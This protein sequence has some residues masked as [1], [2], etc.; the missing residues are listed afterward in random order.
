[1]VAAP[2]SW[3]TNPRIFLNG[4]LLSPQTDISPHALFLAQP[5]ENDYS[6][7]LSSAGISAITSP[8]IYLAA[9][10]IQTP[11]RLKRQGKYTVSVVARLHPFSSL[12]CWMTGST[13]QPSSPF[14]G[15]CLSLELTHPMQCGCTECPRN[16]NCSDPPPFGEAPL[17]CDEVPWNKAL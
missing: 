6:V 5:L 12:W 13:Q 11:R 16:D 8:P 17:R 4:G 10:C 9:P 2:W 1:M 7:G 3:R 14:F 15:T